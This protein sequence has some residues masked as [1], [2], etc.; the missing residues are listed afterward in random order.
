[1]FAGC[2]ETEYL[3]P[4][5]WPLHAE[6]QEH[7]ISLRW[8][9]DVVHVWRQS[10]SR[11]GKRVFQ[12]LGAVDMYSR[13]LILTRTWS[14]AAFGFHWSDNKGILTVQQ[15]EKWVQDFAANNLL[16][17]GIPLYSGRRFDTQKNADKCSVRL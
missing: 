5:P 10:L 13:H 12:R 15:I 17:S 8:M 7:T 2:R 16:R 9:D 14:N 3:S 1:M 6:L 11:G 4:L